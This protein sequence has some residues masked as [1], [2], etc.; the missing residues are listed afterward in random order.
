MS[1]ISAMK[2]KKYRIFKAEKL[3][4][5]INSSNAL[6]LVN[7]YFKSQFNIKSTICILNKINKLYLKIK[8]TTRTEIVFY[9]ENF[10]F[11]L[12][13]SQWY[14]SFR[15]VFSAKY[16]TIISIFTFTYK[17]TIKKYIDFSL[18]NNDNESLSELMSLRNDEMKDEWIKEM[19]KWKNE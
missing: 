6:S 18:L 11:I 4:T 16:E 1:F 2:Q 9:Y 17:H 3:F 10:T 15:H 14:N 19:M 12:H 5:I 8:F 13:I 7:R